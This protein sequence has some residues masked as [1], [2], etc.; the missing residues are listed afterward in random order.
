MTRSTTGYY[1][2]KKCYSL[3]D[4]G[5]KQDDY[6]ENEIY[7]VQAVRWQDCGADVSLLPYEMG[8]RGTECPGRRAILEDAQGNRVQSYGRR[9]GD[10][11]LENENQTV[12][13]QDEFSVASVQNPLVSLG[14]LFKKGWE[15]YSHGRCRS[16]RRTS[17]S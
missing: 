15:F 6:M 7:K 4:Y 3:V 14:R 10:I 11:E 12:I 13:I 1:D 9:L 2:T 16:R 8:H 17:I 5:M